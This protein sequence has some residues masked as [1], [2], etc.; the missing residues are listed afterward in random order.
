MAI[1]YNKRKR[2][3]SLNTDSS[4]YQLKIGNLDYVKHLYYGPSVRD[5]D[6][7]YLI[8]RYDRGFS[9]NPYDSLRE[10]TFSLDAQPQEFTT[11]QQGDFRINSIEVRNANGSA[12]FNG[13]YLS[14]K[15][16]KGPFALNG[17]PVPFAAENDT[18]DTLEIVLEDAVSK[19]QVTLLYSV[20]EEASCVRQ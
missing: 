16:Y 3:F 18:V 7:S 12:S 13:R 11:Q 4:T 1:E 10:R 8:R 17:L 2:T 9:G 20:F 15:I 14:H 5:E 6:M 19:V